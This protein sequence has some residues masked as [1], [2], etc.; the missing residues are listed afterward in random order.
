[1]YRFLTTVFY[2]TCIGALLTMP[3]TAYIAVF[4]EDA[5]YMAMCMG[6]GTALLLIAMY[7]KHLL[8]TYNE[9]SIDDEFHDM[10]YTLARYNN[11]AIR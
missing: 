2:I 4:W 10:R 11:R 8:L 5:T 3:A 1:M 6:T 9:V 7:I